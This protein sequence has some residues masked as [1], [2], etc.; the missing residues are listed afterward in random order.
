[1]TAFLNHHIFSHTGSRLTNME[2]Q[3]KLGAGETVRLL[4]LLN[5]GRKK[6]RI[7]M[8]EAARVIRE[9]AF[10]IGPTLLLMH[11]S[12]AEHVMNEIKLK[13]NLARKFIQ[14]SDGIESLCELI[15]KSVRL[16]GWPAVSY[17]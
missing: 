7:D 16:P 8:A 13:D 1:M 17:N 5:P 9:N 14:G 10:V 12:T 2:L 15:E 11:R 4:Y 3:D 6:D